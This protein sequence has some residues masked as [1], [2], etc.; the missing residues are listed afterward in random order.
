[1]KRKLLLITLALLGLILNC[2][3]QTNSII[4]GSV[5]DENGVGLPGAYVEYLE[6]EEADPINAFIT[7]NHGHFILPVNV[8]GQ[9]IRVQFIGFEPI[10]VNAP[11][12]LPLAIKLTPLSL[13]IQEVDIVEQAPSR[14]TH[15][16][17]KF[18]PTEMQRKLPNVTDFLAQIPFV[19]GSGDHFTVMGKGSTVVYINNR[20]IDDQR[21][22][23]EIKM[24]D[25]LSVDVLPNPG[26]SYGADV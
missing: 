1:M 10:T 2:F 7:D 12:A 3:A 23:K 19:G 5:L 11:F 13:E 26:P 16:G 20:K 17:I 24:E 21:E 9:I 14:I 18:A 8:K 6:N 22:L 15:E 4:S 25:I